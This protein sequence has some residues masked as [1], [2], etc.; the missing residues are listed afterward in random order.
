LLEDRVCR[1]RQRKTHREDASYT[2]PLTS[3]TLLIDELT[4]RAK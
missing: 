3:A 4:H 2:F 1:D